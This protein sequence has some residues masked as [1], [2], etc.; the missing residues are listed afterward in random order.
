V[1]RPELPVEEGKPVVGRLCTAS[2]T[3][4]FGTQVAHEVTDE[5]FAASDRGEYEA[6]CGAVFVA[7]PLVAPVGR[8]CPRCLSVLAAALRAATSTG[9]PRQRRPP[10]SRR[11]GGGLLR[12][13]MPARRTQRPPREG[14]SSDDRCA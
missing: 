11:R 6:L 10:R 12:R 4:Q 3:A 5:A 9:A 8:P 7:A 2:I 1:T 13:L 14:R